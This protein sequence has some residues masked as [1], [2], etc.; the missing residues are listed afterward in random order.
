MLDLRT[1]T[2][3]TLAGAVLASLAGCQRAEE[4]RPPEIRPVRTMTVAKAMAGDIV[5]LNGTVQAQTEI[6]Q[7][8]RIGG[9]LLERSVGIGDTIRPGQP[10]AR[11]DSQN[12]ETSLLAARAQLTGARAQQNEAQSMYARMRDLVAEKAVSQAQYENAQTMAK[13][14]QSQ[15]ESAASQVTLA[16][17][18]VNDT[19]LV[20]NVG[21]V[22]T[23]QG[24]EP[25]EVVAPGQMIVQVAREGGRD[26]VFDVPARAKG[27]TTLGSSISVALTADP[28]VVAT[29]VVRETSPRADPLTGTFRIRAKLNNPP[30]SMRLGSTVTGRMKLAATETIEIPPSAVVRSDRQAAVWIV[31]PKTGTVSSRTIEIKSSDPNR[32]EVASGLNPGDVIVTAGVQALRPGQKVSPLKAAP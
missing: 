22:V 12:E 26:A 6:N 28:N 27:S 1:L 4:A 9:R 14:A 11:L 31:D 32:V 30:P 23:A 15:A 24:A 10:L 19:R 29:A 20:A 13:A 8:F 21:G 2:Y 7:S 3:A 25:G 18:R 5:T 17:T 16:E